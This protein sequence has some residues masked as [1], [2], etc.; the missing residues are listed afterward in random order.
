MFRPIADNA[1]N[2]RFKHCGESKSCLTLESPRSDNG[3]IRPGR[4]RK[5]FCGLQLNGFSGARQCLLR[6]NADLIVVLWFGAMLPRAA[7]QTDLPVIAGLRV[8]PC[9]QTR[10]YRTPRFHLT[11]SPSCRKF[12]SSV[13]TSTD[14]NR[15]SNSRSFTAL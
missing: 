1:H 5:S 7:D 4:R 11:Q 9:F 2:D 15:T 10:K 3:W 14:R 8:Q 12:A 6:A 13:F